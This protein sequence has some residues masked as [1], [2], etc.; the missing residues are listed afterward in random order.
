MSLSDASRHFAASTLHTGIAVLAGAASLAIRG[1]NPASK[2]ARDTLRSL[3]QQ[4]FMD[5]MD[6]TMHG[7]V[8]LADTGPWQ[9]S[10]ASAR[11][12]TKEWQQGVRDR[13]RS[14]S[15]AERLPLP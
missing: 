14:E 9:S 8:A 12:L 4:S 3:S 2:L 7:I 6:S 15:F 11:T 13:M 5:M 1:D 10:D